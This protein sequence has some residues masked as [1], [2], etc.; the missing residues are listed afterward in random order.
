MN[1][2]RDSNPLSQFYLN[3]LYFWQREIQKKP[4]ISHQKYICEGGENFFKSVSQWF[5]GDATELEGEGVAIQ[6]RGFFAIIQSALMH[7]Y[8]V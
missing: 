2:E 3:Q 4:Y 1:G 5:E 6:H 8:F 7:F